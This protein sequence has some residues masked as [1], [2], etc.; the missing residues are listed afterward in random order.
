MIPGRHQGHFPVFFTKLHKASL[1]T[2]NLD[3]FKRFS[4][5]TIFFFTIPDYHIEQHILQPVKAWTS[6]KWKVWQKVQ[7]FRL[8]IGRD[9]IWSPHMQRSWLLMWPGD[10][11][12]WL[13]LQKANHVFKRWDNEHK[14]NSTTLFQNASFKICSENHAG[15]YKCCKGKVIRYMSSQ[16]LCIYA[17]L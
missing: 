1:V 14:Y 6:P 12:R 9:Q 16:A 13:T 15:F 11:S 2:L 8:N 10:C 3:A 4:S 17:F 7:T 5:E